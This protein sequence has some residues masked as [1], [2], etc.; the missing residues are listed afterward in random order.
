MNFY[1]FDFT[2]LLYPFNIW[3]SVLWTDRLSPS[4]FDALTPNMMAFGDGP[5]GGDQCQMLT[6]RWG[7][8]SKISALGRWHHTACSLSP[9]ARGG[10]GSTDW[11]GFCLETKRRGHRIN[12]TLP[13]DVPAFWTVKNECLL[14]MPPSLWYL[15]M[16]AQTD[17]HSLTLSHNYST[18]N[19]FQINEKLD[20]RWKV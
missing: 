13:L 20:W 18:W 15:L 9:S 8:C 2:L 1:I 11:N 6:W 12:P 16:T 14:S 7:S 5:L 19:S 10:P 17:S 4:H 3:G